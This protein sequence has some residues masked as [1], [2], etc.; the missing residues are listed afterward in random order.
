MLKPMLEVFKALFTSVP[1]FAIGIWIWRDQGM[2]WQVGS[3][4]MLA[5]LFVE[6]CM[7]Q[8]KSHRVC[9]SAFQVGCAD[10][11][12]FAGA[13]YIARGRH[14][15]VW[16]TPD[17]LFAECRQA[18]THAFQVWSC[19]S[20]HGTLLN[21]ECVHSHI[22]LGDLNARISLDHVKPPGMLKE[23]AAPWLFHNPIY[24]SLHA[25]D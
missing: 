15:P 23:S 6:F 7:M 18:P 19:S 16:I 17:Q 21:I 9:L 14:L 12:A 3:N 24:P 1:D 22:R 25:E 13:I 11:P 20:Q 5:H 8:A 10:A 4:M 2:P